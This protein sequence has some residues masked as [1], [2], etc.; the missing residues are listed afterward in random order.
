MIPFFSP[1]LLFDAFFFAPKLIR[2]KKPYLPSPALLEEASKGAFSGF[3]HPSCIQSWTPGSANAILFHTTIMM[4]FFSPVSSKLH[5]IIKW[6]YN[7]RP[8]IP[9]CEIFIVLEYFMPLSSLYSCPVAPAAPVCSPMLSIRFPK[10]DL[11]FRLSNLMMPSNSPDSSIIRKWDHYLR[12]FQ[13]C[14]PCF[15]LTSGESEACIL[16]HIL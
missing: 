12:R 2:R 13:I 1:I 3:W 9:F 5:I 8:T 14:I 11:L 15:S 4:L 7:V 10:W 16:H 6:C